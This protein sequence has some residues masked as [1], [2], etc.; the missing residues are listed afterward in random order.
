MR[1][2]GLRKRLFLLAAVGILPLA[3][4][5]GIGLYALAL[6]QREQMERASLELS[7]ALASAVDAEL[8]GAS[9]VLEALAT[10]TSLDSGD[11]QSFYRVARPV[12]ATRPQWRAIILARPDGQVLAHTGYPPGR[13]DLAIAEPESFDQLVQT[14]APLVGPLRR[15]PRGEFGVPVRVPVVREGQLRFVLTGVINPEAFLEVVNRQRVPE[16]WVVSIFDS[17]SARVA[18]SRANAKNIGTPPAP[19]LQRLMAAG[20]DEGVG[21]T[22]ALEGDAVLSAYTRIKGSGWSVAVGIPMSSVEAGTWRSSLA[23][24]GGVLL[25]AV[26]GA[27]AALG[28]A[29]SV[30]RPIAEL[31]R[32]AQALGRGE[33]PT[34][35]PTDIHEI[36]EVAD[37]LGASAEQRARDEA[38]R[39]RLLAAERAAR[40]GAEQARRRLEMLA[41]AGAVLSRSLQP[42]ATLEALASI[43]VPGL[44]DWCR[45]DLVDAEGRLQRAL[46]HHSDPQKSRLGAE[47]VQRLHAS[48]NTPGSMAWT[49]ATGRSHLAHLDRPKDFD[50]ARD[51]DL[52]T[53]AKAIGM[54]SYFIV[55]LVARGRTLGA[56]AALQAE[57]DRGF[58]DDD[59]ALLVE[60]AQ[61]AALALDNARLYADAQMARSQ[62]ERA[63]RAKD[64]F[65]AMLGHELRNPLAPIVT[66]LH[67]MA[68]RGGGEAAM[69]RRIIER[70]VA[71][72]LRLVDDLLDVSRIARGKIQIER[73]RVDM[74]AVVERALELTQPALERRERPIEVDVPSEPVFVAGDAVRLAQV[75]SNLLNNAAKFTAPDERIVL[76]MRRDG[77]DVEIVVEDNGSGIVPELLPRIFDLFTQGEQGM[78]RHS[79]GLGLGLAIVRTLVQLHGGTVVA[80]SEGPG[81]GSRFTLRLPAVD[82]PPTADALPAPATPR[83]R[84]SGRVLLVDDNADAADTLSELLRDAGHQV[85]IAADGA[86]ALA[87]LDSFVPEL[88]LLDI[89]LPGMDGYELASRLRAD[90]RVAGVRIVALTGYGR[91]PDRARAMATNFDEHLVKPVTAERLFD[92]TDRLLDDTADTAA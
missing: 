46:T 48:A 24:G 66:A 37:T 1:S 43:I 3:F 21:V 75:L 81:L 35:A 39:E 32:A 9:Y 17:K 49:V 80:E 33:T 30:N 84:R 78:D 26:L 52:L 22:Y 55:P 19:S 40:S 89:G 82:P 13:S 79:G 45:V 65:L 28:I 6:Q 54:R 72:L 25:S 92:V 36:Q 91:E 62:A 60:L 64:E 57:S 69:E 87:A 2:I 74:K 73:D 29:R 8:R 41:S 15:G 50:S 68:R 47:L 67:L 42:H 51:H 90:P 20:V 61:R 88:A 71:H 58:G 83:P 12:V 44:A 11:M 34:M 86:A 5:S 10:S 85:C 4:M 27:L 14:K 38:E 63:N 23:Y 59:C 76:H 53:F 56:M 31:R 70:Q 18:R 77:A 7:R 16:D